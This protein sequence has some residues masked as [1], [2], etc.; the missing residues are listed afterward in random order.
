MAAFALFDIFRSSCVLSRVPMSV[1]ISPG[2]VS[3]GPPSFPAPCLPPLAAPCNL[4]QLCLVAPFLCATWLPRSTL[5]L[6][7]P[8]QRFMSRFALLL[9]RLP[10]LLILF[11][12]VCPSVHLYLRALMT[13]E[14]MPSFFLSPSDGAFALPLPFFRL[15]VKATT[16]APAARPHISHRTPFPL[17]ACVIGDGAGVPL[18]LAVR[19]LC[20]LG[21]PVLSP[22]SSFR[23]SSVVR[24]IPSEALPLVLT[25]LT[26]LSSCAPPPPLSP[27][28]VNL[29]AFCTC[30]SVHGVLPVQSPSWGS[31]LL[32]PPSSV[33]RRS[34]ILEPLFFSG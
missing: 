21:F 11:L 23:H 7:A 4:P 28:S 26:S 2:Y 25:P 12:T 15:K 6:P 14:R 18:T 13:N 34:A 10:Y 20:P 19:S 16:A 9:Q 29:L 5:H 30:I 31:T 1:R 32:S 27:D 22:A 8:W 33:F 24:S 3:A 17:P